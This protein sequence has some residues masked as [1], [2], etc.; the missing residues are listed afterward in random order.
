MVHS[1]RFTVKLI[2]EKF[3]SKTNAEFIRFLRYTRLSCTKVWNEP[4]VTPDA[5]NRE[6]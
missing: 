4:Y 1:S 5:P 6:P 2:K 3:D